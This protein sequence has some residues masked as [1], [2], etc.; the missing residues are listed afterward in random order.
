MI[1][2]R[3]IRFL[4]QA[5]GLV[6][7]SLPDALPGNERMEEGFFFC[8]AQPGSRH[9]IDEAEHHGLGELLFNLE[10]SSIAIKQINE[11]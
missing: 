6:A 3:R 2:R 9:K 8:F 1:R 10:S 7:F 5:P 11:V 4:R